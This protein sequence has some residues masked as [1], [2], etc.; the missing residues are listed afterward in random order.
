METE[1]HPNMHTLHHKC[2]VT[3]PSSHSQ[4]HF[5]RTTPFHITCDKINMFMFKPESSPTFLRTLLFV[6]L[7]ISVDQSDFLIPQ[8]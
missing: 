1:Q 7:F 6:Y 8:V 3:I 5:T 2:A 4:G